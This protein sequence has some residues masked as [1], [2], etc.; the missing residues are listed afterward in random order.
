MHERVDA[1][2]PLTAADSERAAILFRSLDAFFEPLRTCYVVAPDGDVASVR[3]RVPRNRY[4]VVAESEL[5]PEIGWFRT[6]AR[7]RAKL[8]LAGPPFHG[9]FVQQL[10]K[11]AVA[12]RVATPFYLTLD[13][14]VICVR[15]TRYRDLVVEGRALAQTS[16]PNHPEWNDDAERVLGLPRSGRQWGVTP[17]LIS[18]HAVCALARHLESRV[19]PHLRRAGRRVPGPMRDVVSSWRSFL[20]RSLP[21]TEYALYFT[22]LEQTGAFDRHHVHAGFDAIY[23]DCV[24]MEGQFRDWDPAAAVSPFT[25]VQSATRIPPAR[26]WSKVE[27]LLPR[28]ATNRSTALPSG[29]RSDPRSLPSAL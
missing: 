20:F 21:W 11:L 4:E 15:P 7:V 3:A 5:V 13:A 6:S 2:L 29:R 18:T 10:V 26:V 16:P 23:S 27:P 8:H 25:V 12:E 17:A 22:Y 19:P 14:D 1:V 9:W 28:S 24:W